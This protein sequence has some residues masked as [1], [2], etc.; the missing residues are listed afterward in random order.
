MQGGFEGQGCEDEI[1]NGLEMFT[2]ASS[3]PDLR[4]A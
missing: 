2:K 1:W 4:Q 3:R